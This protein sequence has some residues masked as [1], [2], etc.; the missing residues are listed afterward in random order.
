MKTLTH[1]LIGSILLTLGLFILSFPVLSLWS[2][3]EQKLNREYSVK[4]DIASAK[5]NIAK[6]YQGSVDQGI[7]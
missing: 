3:Q 1:Y 6:M 2:Y 5:K 7:R 4:K